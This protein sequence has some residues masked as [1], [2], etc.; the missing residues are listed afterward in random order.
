[1]ACNPSITRPRVSSLHAG[2][3]RCTKEGN[4][5]EV[6]GHQLHDI[7]PCS[8]ESKAHLPIPHKPSIGLRSNH[9]ATAGRGIEWSNKGAPTWAQ[10]KRLPT[11][12]ALPFPMTRFTNFYE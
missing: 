3:R 6:A 2:A 1:M 9:A 11:E 4:R 5:M 10:R 12:A 7:Q 8:K